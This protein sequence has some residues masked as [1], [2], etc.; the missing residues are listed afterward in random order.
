MGS[1]RQHLTRLL[2]L[3]QASSQLTLARAIV[4]RIWFQPITDYL[5]L[6]PSLALLQNSTLSLLD[7]LPQ[8]S[9]S[10]SPNFFDWNEVISIPEIPHVVVKFA[11][12]DTIY[13]VLIERNSRQ[14]L[15]RQSLR[16]P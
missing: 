10:I 2:T 7:W 12:T 15:L 5:L 8:L 13:P 11:T 3:I 16:T 6:A 14:M 9:V 1:I 4:F